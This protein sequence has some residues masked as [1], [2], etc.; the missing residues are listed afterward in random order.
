MRSGRR[1]S[2]LVVIV[3][4]LT[5]CARP[6]SAMAGVLKSTAQGIR[7]EVNLLSGVLPLTVAVP[8]PERAWTEGAAASS[9]TLANPGLKLLGTSILSSGVVTS[10]AG[11]GTGASGRAESSVAGASLLGTA[12]VGVGAVRTVCVMANSGI[13][14]TT[15]IADLKVAGQSIANPDVNL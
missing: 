10:T 11:P 3:L 9:S 2:T 1:V 6:D 8:N 12:G 5:L 14:T 15:E 13:T 7:A 4:A